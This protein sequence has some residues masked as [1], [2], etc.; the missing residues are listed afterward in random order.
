[1]IDVVDG[2]DV[3]CEVKNDAILDGLLTVFHL[4]RSA[5]ELLNL[6]NDLPLLSDY[7]KECLASL[8]QVG[9]WVWQGGGD[10]GCGCRAGVWGHG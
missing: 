3:V 2:C 6:Q 8:A 5:D 9:V 7:D 1:V 4:E 10:E